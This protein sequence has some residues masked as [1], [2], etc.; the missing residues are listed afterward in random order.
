MTVNVLC[1]ATADLREVTQKGRC[2]AG[3]EGAGVRRG[4]RPRPRGVRAD[5]GSRADRLLASC[6]R[7]NRSYTT[8][9]A[10]QPRNL[11]PLGT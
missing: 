8:S 1:Q 5:C 10:A 4:S 6:A 2:A 9:C 7:F 11:V 3:A